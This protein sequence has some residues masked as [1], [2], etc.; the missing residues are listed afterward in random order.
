M[1]GEDE[2]A[3]RMIDVRPLPPPQRHSRIFKI[4]DEMGA[5]ETLLV[6]NDHEPIHLLQFMK[7]ERRDFDAGSYRAYEKSPG[8]WVGVFKKKEEAARSDDKIVFTSFEKER[9]LDEKAFS[10]IPIY[11]SDRYRVILTYFKAGQFIPVHT[12][13]IDLILV[14]HA[15]K[16]EMVA[17]SQRFELKPGDVAIVPGGET[18]G[19]KAL[20]E[21]EILHLVS[22]PPTDADHEEVV[23][24][25]SAGKF[26]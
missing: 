20:T 9:V 25:L 21:M 10:P 8:E 26:D 12:P 14:V 15:G 11:S 19:I 24:K 5:G 2:K 4:F 1:Q 17:G 18:R 3:R 22:P 13:S 7:H 16:G 23:R 6:V